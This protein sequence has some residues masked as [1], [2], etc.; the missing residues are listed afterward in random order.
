[1]AGERDEDESA[2][3]KAEQVEGNDGAERPEE[4]PRTPERRGLGQLDPRTIDRTG[5]DDGR[6]KTDLTDLR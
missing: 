4:G 3:E 6:G 5:E 1:M 2:E